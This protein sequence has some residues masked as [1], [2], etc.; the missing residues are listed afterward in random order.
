MDYFEF[1][2]REEKQ[3]IDNYNLGLLL[4][5]WYY[6]CTIFIRVHNLFKLSSEVQSYECLAFPHQQAIQHWA[7][8]GKVNIELQLSI[9]IQYVKFSR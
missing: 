3:M 5:V 1:E 7:V 9:K 8:I 4:Y 2:I 6:V